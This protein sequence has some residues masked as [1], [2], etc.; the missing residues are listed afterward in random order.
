MYQHGIIFLFGHKI[1]YINKRK[2]RY[3]AN[4]YLLLTVPLRTDIARRA[5]P[6]VPRGRYSARY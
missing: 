3:D 6:E 5:T 1:G 4:E 2:F